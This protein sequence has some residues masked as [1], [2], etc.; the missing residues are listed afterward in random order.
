MRNIDKNTASFFHKMIDIGA[1]KEFSLTEKRYLRVTNIAS[2]LGGVFNAIWMLITIYLS[3]AALIYGSNGLMG[4]MFLLVLVLN[5]KGWRV[6]ASMWLAISSYISVLL[7]LFLLGYSSG[8]AT[9]CFLIII[10]PYMTFPRKARVFAHSFSLL[11]CLT[12]IATVLIQSK[13]NAHYEGMDSYLLQVVNI[14]IT[15]LICLILIWSLSVL[16]DRSEDS[17][18]AE[19]N[20][21]DE[22]LHN[23]LPVNVARDLKETGKTVPKR[24]K[25]VT[26]LFTDFKD[27]TELV[28]SIPAI[29]LVNELNDIFGRFDEIMEETGS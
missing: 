5:K 29:T 12:L 6:V 16:I 28:A 14:S 19:Q 27:F 20:K 17:L 13:I 3:E 4:L 8:V 26:V 1:K 15:G 24:H 10:L 2:I 9:I 7:F 11:A 18:I 22:L 21:S 23:I 25:N